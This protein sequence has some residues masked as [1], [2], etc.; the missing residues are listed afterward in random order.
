MHLRFLLF[1]IECL[2]CCLAAFDIEKA[3]LT[4]S[5]VGTEVT[6]IVP[7]NPDVKSVFFSTEM[8]DDCGT[9]YTFLHSVNSTNSMGYKQDLKKKLNDNDVLRVFGVFET[10]D[11][12]ITK[13][14][15]FKIDTNGNGV[16]QKI[17]EPTEPKSCNQIDKARLI[18]S[19][20]RDKKKLEDGSCIQAEWTPTMKK[21]KPVCSG[22]L[23]FEENFNDENLQ[24]WDHEIFSR[25]YSEH[26]EFSVF[27]KNNKS[28]FVKNNQ[29]HITASPSGKP[30]RG[31]KFELKNCTRKK[32]WNWS[33]G[34]F[35]YDPRRNTLPPVSSA[36][37]RTKP[38]IGLK[39]GRY[40]VR[41]RMPIG[42]WLF[43]YIILQ[44]EDNEFHDDPAEHIRIA[45]VRGNTKLLD[46]SRNHIGGNVIFG[47]A[48]VRRESS[49]FLYEDKQFMKHQ[50]SG[51]HFG[52][53]FHNYTMIWHSDRI[54]FKVDGIQYG[55]I[56]NKMVLDKL[57][58]KHKSYY[59]ALGLTAGGFHN[60]Q[61]IHTDY[62]LP[63]FTFDDPKAPIIFQEQLS[64]FLSTWTHPNLVID[65]VRVYATDPTED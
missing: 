40:E 4:V 27:L 28:S 8:A 22:D 23:I 63:K 29:L 35:E 33:C 59:L 11:Q 7:E 16:K 47:S 3:E 24:Y 60:F 44:D 61:S 51:A 41:A 10:K 57:N 34:P 21:G 13:S 65:H 5:V 62:N 26:H 18:P 48:F 2:V 38:G 64:K 32:I 14:Y 15:D 36:A 52:N 31:Q 37:I 55:T 53:D 50:K 45:Y 58:A 43:P 56:T 12:V 25:T 1:L 30:K 42:D 9:G 39:Y 19:G 49:G 54:I 20:K 46:T 6:I 17:P